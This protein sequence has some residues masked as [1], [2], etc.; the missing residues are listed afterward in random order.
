M[1]TCEQLN[2][3]RTHGYGKIHEESCRGRFSS[4]VR[5]PGP[6]STWGPTVSDVPV[7]LIQ[8]E[9]LNAAQVEGRAVVEV[10]DEPAWGGDEDVRRC[11]QSCFL[12]LHV[13]ASCRE[14]PRQ[15]AESVSCSTAWTGPCHLPR[16][17]PD[18]GETAE[19]E[20]D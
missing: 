17:V 14:E 13:Q 5:P 3:H 9:H 19:N 18:A 7:S 12:R 1:S 11:P 2:W 6:R 16:P 15:V 20:T 4:G 8:D 10:I